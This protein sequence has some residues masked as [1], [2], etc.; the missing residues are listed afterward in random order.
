MSEN[1]LDE[2]APIF[3]PK[4][5]AVIGASSNLRKFGGRV[6]QVS[7]TFGYSGRLYPVNPQEA[8]VQG[9]KTYA[10][11]KDIP[12]PVDFASIAVPAQAVPGVVQECLEKGVKA[13]QVL[14]AG[15]REAGEEG[16]K[17][18]KE[19][20][21]IA[22]R[23]IRIVGPN[24]FGVY[25][26]DGG[27]TILPGANLPKES[28][29]V[30]FI[31]QSGGYAIR[32]PR[33][34]EGLGIK[35][36]KVVSYGNAC[37]INECDLIEYFYHDPK[38]EII[39]GYIEGVKDGPRFF[40]LLQEVCRKKPVILWKGGLTKGGAR[41]VQSH[42]ASL[43]GEEQ[44]WDAVF[45]QTGAIRVTGLEELLDTTLAFLHLKPQSGRRVC[46]IGGGGGIGVAATD[47]CERMGLS[48]PVFPPE[49]Q[50]KLMS[51][52][53]AA[54]ASARN[55]VDVASPGPPPQMLR[56]VMETVAT[57]ADIDIIIVDEIEMAMFVPPGNEL[58]RPPEMAR[59]VAQVPVDIKNR[60]GKPVVMVLPV[61]NIGTAT[62]EAEGARRRV[63]D[64]FL[65]QGLP[66]YLTLERAARALVNFTGYHQRNAVMSS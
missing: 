37:D 63:C 42:T 60:Y 20:V 66:V 16:A 6:L 43:G 34:S 3:Y 25:S 41:A 39:A 9:M 11:V 46:P 53:P 24:C 64:Y 27:I 62:L 50:K 65:E 48:V 13:V 5:H 40:K 22:A 52:V 30:G 45:R 47:S 28:G 56:E 19:L 12:G 4:T 1:I 21:E 31:S 14:S 61:E 49:L 29:P 17:L 54:G 10:S 51:I 8:E 59:E 36:S 23:G 33:R 57:E 55:P 44:V 38:T 58:M 2:F 7:L 15:F 26:P 35:Y 18:E 32:V